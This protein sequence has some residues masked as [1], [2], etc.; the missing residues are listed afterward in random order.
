MGFADTKVHSKRFL[1][2]SVVL[3]VVAL[4]AFFAS[5]W[6]CE[7][8][9]PWA[10]KQLERVSTNSSRNIVK[11]ADALTHNIGSFVCFYSPAGI[12][13]LTYRWRPLVTCGPKRNGRLTCSNC[14]SLPAAHLM[15]TRIWM[16]ESTQATSL[17]ALIHCRHR[18]FL[19]LCPEIP[20]K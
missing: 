19:Q 1:C 13:S 12:V 15:C 14:N 7:C 8:T 11:Q 20:Y 18:L 6:E 17:L 3:Y 10:M 2:P 5:Y 16:N 4:L 9:G